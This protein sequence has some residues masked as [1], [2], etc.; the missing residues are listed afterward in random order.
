MREIK[1]RNPSSISK[2][3]IVLLSAFISITTV[4][5]SGSSSD[6]ND[7]AIQLIIVVAVISGLFILI[8]GAYA[9]SEILALQRSRTEANKQILPTTVQP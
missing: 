9:V 1:N 3:A 7:D 5:A 6:K 2:T 4:L 8:A